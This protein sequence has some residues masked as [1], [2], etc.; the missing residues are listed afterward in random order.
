MPAFLR[1]R[2]AFRITGIHIGGK[3]PGRMFS[4][5]DDPLL[6]PFTQHPHEPL[7]QVQAIVIEADQLTKAKPAGVKQLE[8]GSIAKIAQGSA[9][10]RFYDCSGF[11]F[12]QVRRKFFRQAR[13]GNQ[14]R[15][16]YFQ[17]AV[18]NEESEERAKTCKL[19][20]NGAFL[21]SELI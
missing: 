18:A 21:K 20:G 19:T 7:R 16:I 3:S 4:E 15:R 11:G 2:D 13:R 8:N 14:F 12:R 1:L 6:S 5:R 9:L 10:G 17:P